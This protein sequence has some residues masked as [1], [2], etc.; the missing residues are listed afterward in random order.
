MIY[1]EQNPQRLFNVW[2]EFDK[3]LQEGTL[4][5]KSLV[6]Y[7]EAVTQAHRNL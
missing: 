6:W 1:F 7:I 5:D 2:K 3:R 4:S